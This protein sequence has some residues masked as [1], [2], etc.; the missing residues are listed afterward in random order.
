M[1]ELQRQGSAN[2]AAYSLAERAR[3]L[4]PELQWGHWLWLLDVHHCEGAD[5][6]TF[7]DDLMQWGLIHT[8]HWTDTEL[9]DALRKEL[10]ALRERLSPSMLRHLQFLVPEPEDRNRRF[11]STT[12]TFE[13]LVRRELVD[14]PVMCERNLHVLKP[15]TLRSLGRAVTTLEV[16][17]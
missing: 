13:A 9:C 7:L 4:L 1:P 2:S 5:K 6:D 8:V 11:S 10:R 16:S 15:W 17:T 12:A 14:R 3:S